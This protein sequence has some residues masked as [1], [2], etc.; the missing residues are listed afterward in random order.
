MSTTH[1]QR[2]HLAHKIETLRE[3][4]GRTKA[5]LYRAANISQTAYDRRIKGDIDF[6]LDELTHIAQ[7]LDTTVSKL[8]A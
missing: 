3:N 6:R 1:E 4:T 7:A 5:Y 2:Q 8:T